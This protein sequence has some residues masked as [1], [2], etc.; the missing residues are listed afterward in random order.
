MLL[1][2]TIH[3]AFALRGRRGGSMPACV[4]G[5][6]LRHPNPPPIARLGS[7]VFAGAAALLWWMALQDQP[8]TMPAL[9]I[10]GLLVV[11][12]ARAPAANGILIVTG[13][14]LV[15]LVGKDY[16]PLVPPW[17]G[18]PALQDS[19]PGT[20]L[21]Q[22]NPQS[23]NLW[24]QAGWVATVGVGLAALQAARLRG[25]INPGR[26]QVF[27]GLLL[28]TWSLAVLWHTRGGE[29]YTV[30]HHLLAVGSKNAAA[31]LS[32]LGG[33]L[34]VGLAWQAGHQRSPGLIGAWG[35]ATVVAL[36][37]LAELRSWTGVM[38]FLAG[39][40]VLGIA[41]LRVHTRLRR[42]PALAW[43][44][45][46]VLG[47]L[48]LILQLSPE[49][50]ARVGRLSTD[51]RLEL[52]RDC[53]PLL[54]AFPLGGSGLGSFANLYPLYSTIALA[55]DARVYHPD[56]S[57]VLLAG[58]WGLPA[59]LLLA[60]AAVHLLKPRP[61]IG[62][63][64]RSDPLTRLTAIA[65]GCGWLIT[66]V[67]DISFHRPEVAIPALAVCGLLPLP[68]VP[69]RWNRPALAWAGLIVLTGC[70]VAGLLA[71]QAQQDS[72]RRETFSTAALRADPLQPRLH[73]FA[74]YDAWNR[75]GDRTRALA[76]LR[77]AVQLDRHSMQ[78][79]RQAAELLMPSAPDQ[80]AWFWQQAL[81]RC[82]EDPGLGRGLLQTA[83]R[84]FPD[85]PIDYW[86]EVIGAGQPRLLV[87]LARHSPG[88]AE[89]LLARWWSEAGFAGLRIDAD[90]DDFFASLKKLSPD[91]P[92]GPELLRQF[93]ADLPR[94]WQWRA[95][96]CAV[97]LAA[98]DLAWQIL[99]RQEPFA[100][101][102]T[103][104]LAAT[105]TRWR[106]WQEALA[107]AAPSPGHP[108]RLRLLRALLTQ[109]DPPAWLRFQLALE[110][111]A[112]GRTGDA[113]EILLALTA[114]PAAR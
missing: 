82:R 43:L 45:L 24:Q 53:L 63:D 93:P 35:L 94:T 92:L 36:L 79:A 11:M 73:W 14:I 67:T 4:A 78:A 72:V 51:F 2:S 37:A 5:N 57:W 112:A 91:H 114:V 27:F 108:A 20:W 62:E 66:G 87:L 21:E 61:G 50:A 97:D 104:D 55:P 84:L 102:A 89:P 74:A 25:W 30:T 10:V 33:I 68:A 103:D 99:L 106:L 44:A 88:P 22:R 107:A 19:V 81:W 69:G 23:R 59:T 8:L 49:L 64:D 52:W 110:L 98:P 80:A 109:S 17:A 16:W 56:S 75:A 7:V 41:A 54:S 70:L 86:A 28:T 105:P 96:Q 34:A 76:H 90:A 83:W 3:F 42:G 1:R 38:G 6:H 101:W 77:T 46:P 31:T 113:V 100:T 71:A 15:L 18:H 9:G 29:N 58:E 95:A 47:L 40:L 85:R 60:G 12:P 39:V 111:Q 48:L 13:L 65:T 32:A 26:W